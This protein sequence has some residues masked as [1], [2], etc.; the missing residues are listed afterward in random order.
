M[1]D[2]SKENKTEQDI[3]NQE[4]G[5]VGEDGAQT[6]AWQD[7]LPPEDDFHDADDL[8]EETSE[9]TPVEEEAGAADGGSRR[10]GKNILFG[11]L[12]VGALAIGAMAYF[13]FGGGGSEPGTL[14]LPLAGQGLQA[15]QTKQPAPS[16][17]EPSVTPTTGESDISA[18]YKAAQQQ[19]SSAGAMAL[20][21][22]EVINQ[23]G[24]KSA[25][26][27]STEIMTMSDAPSA[28]SS[29]AVAPKQA[30]APAPT[31]A[32]VENI[33]MPQLQKQ[34]EPAPIPSKQQADA[35]APLPAS[36]SDVKMGPS[37]GELEDRLKTM[38]EHIDS[39]KKELDQSMQK[40]AELLKRIETMQAAV[41]A[42]DPEKMALELR[43]KQLEEQLAAAQTEQPKSKKKAEARAGIALHA[44]TALAPEDSAISE[45]A[46]KKATAKASAKKKAAPPKKAVEP[47]AQGW[48]LRAATPEAAWV[49]KGSHAAD[50]RRVAVGESLEGLG[51]IKE[52]RQKGDVWELVGA[53]GT[54]R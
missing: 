32:K 24:D 11:I 26:G 50:L 51:R 40:N 48:V 7:D 22:G 15:S 33:P 36:L 8:H 25:L 35:L 46:Q 23:N 3:L 14:P 29:A 41:P 12:V 45:P 54:L 13:Q 42:Q 43:L 17:A 30:A 53:A 21:N 49:S 6:E 27:T 10:R 38:G 34:P 31:V 1:T 16:A 19:T 44:E 20:P 5:L 9:E 52:I 18:L 4:E 28:P 39:L 47:K 37:Q 2:Q